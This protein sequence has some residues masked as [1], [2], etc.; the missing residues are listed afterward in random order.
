LAGIWALNGEHNRFSLQRRIASWHLALYLF[1]DLAKSCCRA[2][3][4]VAGDLPM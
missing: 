4:I 1:P 3:A 2:P